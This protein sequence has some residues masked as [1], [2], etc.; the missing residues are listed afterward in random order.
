MPFSNRI[1]G[2]AH[3]LGKL[4]EFVQVGV[5]ADGNIDGDLNGPDYEQLEKDLKSTSLDNTVTEKENLPAWVNGWS[6]SVNEAW[7]W[8]WEADAPEKDFER[9]VEMLKGTIV[10]L[11]N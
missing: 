11:G 6:V 2:V 1:V 7:K 9:A 10:E 8:Q 5:K 4:Y 3:E